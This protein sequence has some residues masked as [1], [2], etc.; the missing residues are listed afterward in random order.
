M[1]AE[2]RRANAHI[3]PMRGLWRSG[4]GHSTAASEPAYTELSAAELEWVARRVQHAGDFGF[5]SCDEDSISEFFGVQLNA[6]GGGAD[7]KVSVGVGSVR[8]WNLLMLVR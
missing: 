1:A 2:P 3:M 6:A 5:D 8:A 7:P 4:L